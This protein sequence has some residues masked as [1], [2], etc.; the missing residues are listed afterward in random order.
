MGWKSIA[1]IAGAILCA[2]ATAAVITTSILK[3]HGVADTKV[4]ASTTISLSKTPDMAVYLDMASNDP[5]V[6]AAAK[7]VQNYINTVRSAHCSSLPSYAQ[8]PVVQ[9]AKRTF[10]SNHYFFFE[11]E[12]SFG[13]NTSSDVFFAKTRLSELNSSDIF[14]NISCTPE[15]C[16]TE[17]T[18]KL[19]ISA[20]G[21]K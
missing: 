5:S 7:A 2:M 19:A 17:V 10:I 21:V 9:S 14:E 11:F 15:P 13:S 12:M 16:D 20:L 3:V 4:E 8:T 18:D 6:A 1:K